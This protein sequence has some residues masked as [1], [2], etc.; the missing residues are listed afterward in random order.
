MCANKSSQGDSPSCVLLLK[1]F[2]NELIPTP[3]RQ[4]HVWRW[5]AAIRHASR[6]AFRG[7][8]SGEFHGRRDGNDARHDIVFNDQADARTARSPPCQYRRPANALQTFRKSSGSL[9]MSA[10]LRRAS[11]LVSSLV[12]ESPSRPEGGDFGSLRLN[13]KSSC[14]GSFLCSGWI[15]HETYSDNRTVICLP[16]GSTKFGRAY[17]PTSIS[18]DTCQPWRS[19]HASKTVTQYHKSTKACRREAA[20]GHDII[21]ELGRRSL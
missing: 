10:A 8:I 1:Y 5:E 12:A 21:K 4:G 3:V 14:H 16:A 18:P 19:V 9:A 11:F 2:A 7:A 17:F 13:T 6:L 20:R 15:P